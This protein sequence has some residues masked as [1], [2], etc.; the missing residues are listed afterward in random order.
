MLFRE[1][2]KAFC[3]AHAAKILL[4]DSADNAVP[5]PRSWQTALET[6]KAKPDFVDLVRDFELLAL[7]LE[8]NALETDVIELLKRVPIRTP[9]N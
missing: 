6:E 5:V 2:A 8:H 1:Y 4:K 9:I 3:E 7:R